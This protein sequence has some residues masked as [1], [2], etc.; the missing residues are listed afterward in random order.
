MSF[1]TYILASQRNVTLYVGSKRYSSWSLRPWLVTTAY[2]HSAQV[3]ERR[4]R[5]RTWNLGLVI[6]AFLLSVFGTFIVRSGILPSVHTFALSPIG[7][8]FFGFL[9]VSIVVSGVVL[10]WR[11]PLLASR[12][13]PQATVSREAIRRL[14]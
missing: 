14:G 10:A 11:S 5:L 1:W 7:P 4:G 3:Q 2:I 8:W 9:A 13:P 6:G 12:Q